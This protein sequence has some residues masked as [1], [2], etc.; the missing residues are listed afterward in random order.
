MSPCSPPP[1]GWELK[2]SSPAVELEFLVFCFNAGR[3]NQLLKLQLQLTVLNF[4]YFW[5]HFPWDRQ[6]LAILA[7]GQGAVFFFVGVCLFWF[8]LFFNWNRI[9]IMC[10][11]H[12][13][14]WSQKDKYHMISF[15]SG[16]KEGIWRRHFYSAP[17]ILSLTLVLYFRSPWAMSTP[18]FYCLFHMH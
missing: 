5:I 7:I 18:L 3:R 6:L 2:E 14:K 10:Q 11:S 15:I 8:Y 1:W 12:H 13:S 17:A 16:I 9:D 4:G